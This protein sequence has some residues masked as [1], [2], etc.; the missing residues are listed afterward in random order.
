VAAPSQLPGTGR[1]PPASFQRQRRQKLAVKTLPVPALGG[2]KKAKA[3]IAIVLITKNGIKKQNDAYLKKNGPR[4][5]AKK[6]TPVLQRCGIN[7]KEL[8][9]APVLTDGA[10][11]RIKRFVL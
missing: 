8:I 3:G 1:R 7:K 6:V 11:T 9:F 10:G 4:P 5:I 2:I